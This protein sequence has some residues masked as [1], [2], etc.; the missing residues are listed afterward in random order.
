MSTSLTR[1]LL[2]G[3]FCLGA[4]AAAALPADLRRRRGRKRR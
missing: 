1:R 2:L 3:G 4:L